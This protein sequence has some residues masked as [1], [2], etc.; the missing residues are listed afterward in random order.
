MNDQRQL[1]S[2][3]N[4][5][6]VSANSSTRQSTEVEN[7]ALRELVKW[8]RENLLP[9]QHEMLRFLLLNYS[10]SDEGYRYLLEVIKGNK[11]AKLLEIGDVSPSKGAISIKSIGPLKNINALQE[12]QILE[13]EGG[14]GVNIVFGENG[15]GKSG[16]VRAVKKV[17]DSGMGEFIKEDS[18]KKRILGDL[19]KDYHGLE[20]NLGY[21]F[22][23]MEVV[24]REIFSPGNDS[25]H[26]KGGKNYYEKDVN[27]HWSLRHIRVFDSDTA[28][29]YVDKDKNEMVRLPLP[30]D[31]LYSLQFACGAMLKFMQE[32]KKKLDKQIQQSGETKRADDF[33]QEREKL[34]LEFIKLT[35]L[36]LSQKILWEGGELTDK[37]TNED[38]KQKFQEELKGFELGHLKVELW[39]LSRR[40]MGLLR[41]SFLSY[42]S[43]FFLFY[44]RLA[45]V[46][47]WH[48]RIKDLPDLP[49][50]EVL[51][52]GE[53]RGVAL[54]M[55]FAE[56]GATENYSTVVFDDP[57]S[58]MDHRYRDLVAQR[59]ASEGKV[60]QVIVFTH[61]Q[62]F[63]ES[64]VNACEVSEVTC[65]QHL[66]SKISG[67]PGYVSKAPTSFERLS[68]QKGIEFLKGEIEKTKVENFIHWN[69][70]KA[71]SILMNVR[72]WLEKFVR[73]GL[74]AVGGKR[75]QIN[76]ESL[77]KVELLSSD[78]CK[79]V[80]R[81]KNKCNP[82][83]HNRDAK[84]NKSSPQFEEVEKILKEIDK[85]LIP[86][87]N[88]W[89]IINKKRSSRKDKKI[90][91]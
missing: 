73:E 25:E 19:S 47:D 78:V 43:Y 18:I 52:E 17:S 29:R 45:F 63:E 33:I 83:V 70:D 37:F 71:D 67:V 55:F 49:R 34:V 89:K 77:E 15:S 20:V 41:R 66:I 74:S 50:S 57:V 21:L 2:S 8:A 90:K 75:E 91:N 79:K 22:D 69:D 88:E 42:S 10:V 28:R 27:S 54:A 40:E 9:W 56:L 65:K 81:I 24:R 61:D 44:F 1:P 51:S 46:Q 11:T 30:Q 14:P 76:F 36:F 53:A 72:K 64:L 4:D 38:W 39:F 32:E 87:V 84:K 82:S 7:Q 3:N 23:G 13:F 80:V 59:I 35:D 62:Y 26:K 31:L 16:Y 6:P 86:I 48:G 5:E 12:E 58:S 68:L 60:R 85:D